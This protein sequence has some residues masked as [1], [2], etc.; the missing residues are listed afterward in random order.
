MREVNM[1]VGCIVVSPE[2]RNLLHSCG[3]T[4]LAA[5]LVPTEELLIK[6]LVRLIRQDQSATRIAHNEFC[7]Y[8]ILAILSVNANRKVRYRYLIGIIPVMLRN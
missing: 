3:L 4:Q 2:G 8:E 7:C 6:N 5:R 1:C